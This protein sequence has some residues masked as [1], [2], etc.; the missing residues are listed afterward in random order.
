MKKLIFV[1]GFKGNSNQAKIAKSIF[2]DYNFLIFNYDSNLNQSIEEIAEELNNFICKNTLPKEK[3]YLM[4]VSAGGIICSYFSKFINPKKVIALGTICAPFNGTYVPIFYSKK[5]GGLQEL[6]YH[7]S[8]LKKI[9]Y[10]KSKIKEINFYSYFDIL[11]PGKSGA[12]KNAVHT[13]KFFHFTIHNNKQILNKI[14]I[15]FESK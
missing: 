6:K 2:S 10:S 8:L 13:S 9:K 7:S 1:Y 12:S 15:F 11:V 4:G 3:V 14:K 5:L